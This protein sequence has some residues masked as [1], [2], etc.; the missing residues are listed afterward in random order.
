VIAHLERWN[1]A[2]DDT[3]GRPLPQTVAGRL[4]L[5]LA[6]VARSWRAGAAAGA[7]GHPLVMA[8]EARAAWL[9]R[10][11]QL[12]L[13]LRGPR[14][15]PGLEPIREAVRSG[16][17]LSGPFGWW[18]E[19]EGAAGPAAAARWRPA[20]GRHADLLADLPRRCAAKAS[21]AADGRAWRS[22]S[23]NGAMRRRRREACR[24]T[25]ARCPRCC[26]MRWTRFR[27]ARPMAAI[28]AWR[29]MACSKRG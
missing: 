6:E 11:R 12:D 23:S 22:S 7:A 28:R 13:V 17:A 29:S 16:K 8:G 1:I 27:C 20:A 5:Q 3:A 24:S 2:A 10:V 21:G 14:P 4:F 9:E 19:V 25:R 18:D 26:A 15:G